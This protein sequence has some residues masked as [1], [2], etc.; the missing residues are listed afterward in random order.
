MKKIKYFIIVAL[1]ALFLVG[2]KKQ[3][4]KAPY[5]I[6]VNED[7]ILSW[8]AVDEAKSY[9]VQIFFIDGNETQVASTRKTTFDLGELEVGD[10]EISI[11]SVAGDSKYD[12]SDF[13]KSISFHKY[14]ESGCVYEL[15]NNDSE[16][17]VKKVG[18]AT[19][20]VVI[21]DYYR[22]KA[23]TEVGKSCFKGCSK[24][25]EV[26]VGNNVLIIG[27]NAF[28]NCSK[29]ERVVLPDELIEIGAGCFHSC[30]DL[31]SITIPDGIKELSYETF[32]HCKNLQT[33]TLSSNLKTIGNSCF[34]NCENIRNI[35]IPNTVTTIG[36]N[37]FMD[38]TSLIKLEIGSG[39]K[40]IGNKAFYECLALKNILFSND[41]VLTTL[42]VGSFAK[43][44]SLVE[45]NL[46]NTLENL[47]A[48]CFENCAV[49]ETI[50]IP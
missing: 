23:V 26:V 39:V 5:N 27:E 6:D 8:D 35:T 41:S 32:S 30:K 10:Y 42:G 34:S 43:C 29:L 24:V 21:E 25:T 22:N 13:S 38:C 11:Q 36:D 50:S 48:S 31:I 3:K 2:C 46:P 44:T 14:F 33:V 17:R 7:L 4:I 18:K 47:G 20:A 15:I 16:Y 28:Y 49:F 9:N 40:T 1:C 12:D 19:G 37:A 45:I